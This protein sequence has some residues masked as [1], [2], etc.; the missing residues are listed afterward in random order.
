VSN[1]SVLVDYR[2]F[3]MDFRFYAGWEDF[4]SAMPAV[5]IPSRTV[6]G[7]CVPLPCG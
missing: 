5:P 2:L 3:G 4:A 7:T 6:R 1:S